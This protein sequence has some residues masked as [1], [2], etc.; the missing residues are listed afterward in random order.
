MFRKPCADP[1]LV[2]PDSR[3]LAGAGRFEA[4][5]LEL[6]APA[7]GALSG[8]VTGVDLHGV[9]RLGQLLRQK[10]ELQCRLLL[11]LYPAC[12]TDRRE[13]TALHDLQSSSG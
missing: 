13:L 1:P 12:P 9:Q 3:E 4:P 11:G 2:W 7:A 6:L 5:V 10:P 8:L